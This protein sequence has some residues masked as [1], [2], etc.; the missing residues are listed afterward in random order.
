MDPHSTQKKGRSCISCH[1][2]PRAVGLGTGELYYRNGKWQF[3]PAM[4]AASNIPG[5]AH[6]LDAFVD[7]SGT[8]LVNTSKST[9][10]PFNNKEI[11]D[12]MYVGLCLDCHVDFRDGVMKNWRSVRPPQPCTASNLKEMQGRR[13]SEHVR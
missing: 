13:G 6:P 12:I 9:L 11:G 10:R 3:Q 1:Q 8:S 5:L 2:D 4:A 7:I